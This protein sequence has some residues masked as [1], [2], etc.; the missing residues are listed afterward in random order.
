MY[1]CT[2]VGMCA[3]YYKPYESER[4]R[5]CMYDNTYTIVSH[6][7]LIKLTKLPSNLYR[8]LLLLFHETSIFDNMQYL[9]I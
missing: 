6:V 1:A 7:Q 5:A 9:P 4:E 8:R 3:M 2:Y